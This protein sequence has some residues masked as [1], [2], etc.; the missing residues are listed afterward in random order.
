MMTRFFLFLLIF[1]LFCP[2]HL[3]AAHGISIDGKVS[4][5]EGFDHF[6]YVNPA[7]PKGGSLTLHDLGGFDKMNPFT[8]KGNAPYGLDSLI[9]ET[10]AVPSLDEPFAEYG[11]IAKDIELAEDKMSVTYTLDERARFSDGSPVTVEDVAYSLKTLKSDQAHP[12]YQ[13][14]LQDIKEA[15]I[16]DAR[17]IRFH[18]QR[19]NR[20]LHLIA[21]QLPVLSRAFYAQHPFDATGSEAAMKPPVGSGP[22]IVADVNPGK[23]ITYRRNPDYWAV[24]HPTRKGMFNFDRITV[25]YFKDQIVSVEAFKAGEFD[26]MAVN[27]AKQW[28]RDL[29]GRHFASGSLVKKVYPHRNNAGM[30]GFVFNTR[31]PLFRDRLVR[32]ALGL[33]LDFEWI[34][35]T[36]FFGQYT[37][38][39]SYFSNSTL[40]AKGL[41]EGRELQLLEPFRD[42]LPPEVF[43]APLRPP[44]TDPPSSLRA[45]LR[46]AKEL[47]AQA[48][49]EVR[50]SVLRNR[51]GD[52]FSFEILLVSPSF[53]RVMAPYVKNLQKLGIQASYRTID[54]ALFTDRIKNF[55]F[56]MVV[57]VF[58]QSQSPGNEQRDYWHS[59]AADRLGSRNLAGISDP[60]VDSLVDEII[61]AETQDEL[62]AACRALDRVLW[63]G[64]YVVP[65]WYMAGWR[66]AYSSR[67]RQPAVLPHYYSPNQLLMTWWDT[68]AAS[69]R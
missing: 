21:S 65:N 34:N 13:I 66:L 7:A 69:G 15:E 61:Y 26:F 51:Q 32:K 25:K 67:L 52:P 23:S 49:W 27:I 12:F 54:A 22:Y 28:E 47:L 45:N 57:N 63:Y 11:L 50:D 36:L 33:A 41:P 68:T 4:Y 20:E 19:T 43:T 44:A 10:L 24:D 2:G 55:D 35:T 30:Q 3:F 8:L 18:F 6:A 56:D 42:Q 48:G 5:P 58:G 9:F 16:L 59:G 40:A 53:E 62:T 14:Y 60:V 64:Y 1:F 38:S 46:E 37:R 29:I 17:R 39:D 31:R